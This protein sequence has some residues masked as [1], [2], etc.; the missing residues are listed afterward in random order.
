MRS[1]REVQRLAPRRGR[2]RHRP[3]S[4]SSCDTRDAEAV[5]IG[6]VEFLACSRSAP[7]RPRARTSC[8]DV[9]HD[10]VD[11]RRDL[12]LGR[13]EGGEALLEIGVGLAKRDGHRDAAQ[14]PVRRGGDAGRS[15]APPRSASRASMHSTS[16]RIAPPPAN[17]QLDDAGRR[18]RSASKRIASSDSTSSGLSRSMPLAAHRQHAVEMQHAARRRSLC[19]RLQL[20]LPPRR[21]GSWRRRELAA[22]RRIQAC[23]RP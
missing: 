17:D 16:S 2:P 9:A 7:R 8:D 13:Q 23:R 12:A 6:P 19:L 20:G 18:A 14:A 21:S 1:R 5:E 3:A 15:Q 22:A 4:I 11:I 10:G